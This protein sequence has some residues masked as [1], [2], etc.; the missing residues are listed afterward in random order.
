MP[1]SAR[2]ISRVVL[3]RLRT[4]DV[5]A[6]EALHAAFTQH[7][8]ALAASDK[9]LATELVY[10]V[11]RH[12]RFLL[13]VLSQHGDMAKTK[14]AVIDV[15]LIAAYQLLFLRV[16]DFAAVDEAVASVRTRQGA[17]VAGFA[18]AILRQ[19]AAKSAQWRAEHAASPP[20]LAPEV[21]YSLPDWMAAAM[22]SA[23][24]ESFLAAAAA[25]AEPARLGLR[26][27][28]GGMTVAQAC[29]QLAAADT[30]A[31][32]LPVGD[33]PHAVTVK[34]LG[35][36]RQHPLFLAG[37]ITVQDVAAQLCGHLVAP[38]P[39][40]RILDMCAGVGGKA[41]QL[42][43]LAPT[44]SIDACDMSPA[45]LQRLQEA[46]ARLG[47]NNITAQHCDW[48][49]EDPAAIAALAAR[50]PYDAILLDAP[51]SGLGILRRHP[52]I[53]WRRLPTDVDRSAKASWALLD[54]AAGLVRPG[55]RLVFAVCTWTRKE[56]PRQL[57]EFLKRHPSFAI[58]SRAELIAQAPYLAPYVGQDGTIATWPHLHGCDGF[59][60]VRLQRG[61]VDVVP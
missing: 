23:A 14:A 29:E 61:A 36:L 48:L 54:I 17:A 43:E 58:A 53:K 13:H 26:I 55:G 22:Q 56:G 30:M 50:Q 40:E 46:C 34:S 4:E 32:P 47:V 37:Q 39:Q 45:K 60:A 12:R 38:R 6:S 57:Q 8:N 27:R 52:E 19:V 18:N 35:N 31:A 7:G 49:A 41:T 9:G 11:S 5:L 44:A 10:G 20:T 1:S 21:A 42:A 2:E 28:A 24:G 33:V 25:F 59:F 16:P 15:L 51:C 3:V